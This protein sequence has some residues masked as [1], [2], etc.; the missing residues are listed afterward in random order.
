MSDLYSYS[1][2]GRKTPWELEKILVKIGLPPK[3]AKIYVYLLTNGEKKASE[4]SMATQTSKKGTYLLLASLHNK[5]LITAAFLHPIRFRAVQFHIAL[6]FLVSA[7][8]GP[9]RNYSS[10]Q[11]M[12][13]GNDSRAYACVNCGLPYQVYP[14]DDQHTVASDKI[15]EYGDSRNVRH[16]CSN[17]YYTNEL[18]WHLEQLHGCKQ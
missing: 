7:I 16:E 15:S 13:Q 17:C 12:S 9:L 8:T 2:N 6:G 18:H 1:T 10:Y 11:L 4:I 3:E 14:P 5:G